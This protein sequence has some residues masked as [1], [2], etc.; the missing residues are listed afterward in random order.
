[1]S[2]PLPGRCPRD[3]VY[4]KFS[5]LRRLSRANKGENPHRLVA[6]RLPPIPLSGAPWLFSPSYPVLT[7]LY[8]FPQPMYIKKRSAHE[9][10]QTGRHSHQSRTK[11]RSSV[12]NFCSSAALVQTSLLVEI[13]S[14]RFLHVTLGYISLLHDLH[15]AFD[16][17]NASRSGIF[18]A[19]VHRFHVLLF[20]HQRSF[21]HW[22][23]S[24]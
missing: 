9:R 4:T 20:G 16:G 14:H 11:G 22:R 13:S 6:T 21:V 17:G 18:F 1:M 2:T 3:V 24:H 7:S 10:S 15:L 23:V 12:R 8:E 19:A 5:P